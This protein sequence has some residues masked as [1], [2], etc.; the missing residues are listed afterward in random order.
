MVL[1]CYKQ[2]KKLLE[3]ENKTVMQK[4][5]EKDGK[6]A[7]VLCLLVPAE[8]H[9]LS[10]TEINHSL[11]TLTNCWICGAASRQPPP[12]SARRGLQLVTQFL[13]SIPP[14]QVNR[15]PA[16]DTPYL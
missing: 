16:C 13:S 2:Q 12:K 15:V 6:L 5:N 10:T 11:C 14:G 7:V 1:I 8:W 3:L 9:V 4:L